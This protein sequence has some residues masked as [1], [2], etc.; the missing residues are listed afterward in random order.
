MA[1]IEARLIH[2][3]SQPVTEHADCVEAETLLE[4]A[5]RRLDDR[6][7]AALL[8]LAQRDSADI[9]VADAAYV[10][11]LSMDRTDRLLMSLVDA[12]LLETAGRARY[13]FLGV[14]KLAAWRW[15]LSSSRTNDAPSLV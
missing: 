14:V 8:T 1:E 4:R 3:L 12:H 2:D 7:A 13:R 10:L 11:G 6:L 5:Y 15:S 9:A